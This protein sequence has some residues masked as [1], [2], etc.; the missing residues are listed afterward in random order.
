[1]RICYLEEDEELNTCPQWGSWVL[2][3]KVLMLLCLV[4]RRYLSV[5]GCRMVVMQAV[6]VGGVLV[7]VLA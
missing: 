2:G 1:M 5:F 3:L 7:L 6:L 4:L